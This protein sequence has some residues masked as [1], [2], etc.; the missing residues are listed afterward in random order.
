MAAAG[1]PAYQK[2]S[3]VSQLLLPLKHFKEPGGGG[4][5]GVEE[6]VQPAQGV[7]KAAEPEQ[8]AER[9]VQLVEFGSQ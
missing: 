2:P 9:L 6:G 3:P 5:G 7:V 8:L 1:Q 4:G